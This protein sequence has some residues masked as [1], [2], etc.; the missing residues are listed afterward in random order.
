MTTEELKNA[1]YGLIGDIDSLSAGETYIRRE[2]ANFAR[3]VIDWVDQLEEDVCALH[4][5][6]V[7]SEPVHDNESPDEPGPF[8]PLTLPIPTYFVLM[9]W[10]RA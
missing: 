9:G 2:A 8:A 3:D 5:E 7:E 6:P 1:A 10:R 4:E